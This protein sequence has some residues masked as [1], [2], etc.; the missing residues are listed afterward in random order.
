[1]AA[2]TITASRGSPKNDV[3]SDIARSFETFGLHQLTLFSNQIN[4]QIKSTIA[5]VVSFC[6]FLQ[7]LVR[8]PRK[9]KIPQLTCPSRFGEAFRRVM[10]NSMRL[11]KK[12]R[13]VHD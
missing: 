12:R 7:I 8:D 5:M 3:P 4:H 9:N 1:L 13:G 2:Q 6:S 10:C 11:S